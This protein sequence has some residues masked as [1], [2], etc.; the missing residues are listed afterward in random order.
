MSINLRIG[1]A[2]HAWANVMLCGPAKDLSKAAELVP[3]TFLTPYPN[4]IYLGMAEYHEVVR[5]RLAT[6]PNSEGAQY[7]G[8]LLIVRVHR[9]YY[10]QVAYVEGVK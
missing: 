7:V 9:D 1:E 4:T 8:A 10:L 5:E 2:T 6:T 3:G